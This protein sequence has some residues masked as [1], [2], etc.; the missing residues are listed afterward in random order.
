MNKNPKR[1][2]NK[3]NSKSSSK[4]HSQGNVELSTEDKTL[5]DFF[6]T[7]LPKKPG[8]AECQADAEPKAG[9]N[10][11]AAPFKSKNDADSPNIKQSPAMGGGAKDCQDISLSTTAQGTSAAHSVHSAKEKK[12][13]ARKPQIQDS[14]KELPVSP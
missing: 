2:K 1:S 12:A 7:K 4:K 10:E 8:E 11:I 5:N 14:K 3:Q 13:S 9:K 6:A